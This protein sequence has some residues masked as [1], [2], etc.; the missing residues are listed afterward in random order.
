MVIS[1]RRAKDGRHGL[2]AR[3]GFFVLCRQTQFHQTQDSDQE[4]RDVR[5]GLHFAAQ[6]G[7]PPCGQEWCE[8]AGRLA[9][10][11]G[12]RG[13]PGGGEEEEEDFAGG[14]IGGGGLKGGAEEGAGHEGEDEGQPNEPVGDLEADLKRDHDGDGADIDYD[15]DEDKAQPSGEE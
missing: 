9:D 8:G 3:V 2:L 4:T 1:R 10:A 7:T 11:I 12:R 15:A 6:G 5:D 14:G 13:E